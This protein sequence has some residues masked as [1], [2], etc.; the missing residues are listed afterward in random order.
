M[1]S[2][3]EAII[4]GGGIVG[5]AIAFYL[6][7]LGMRDVV[8]I[9]KDRFIGAGATAKC[10]G[11]IRAQFSSEINIKMSLMSENLLE[12][13]QDETGEEGIFDQCGYLFMVSTDEHED[14]FRKNMDLQLANDVPVEWLTPDDIR[15][16]APNVRL[17]DILGGTFCHKDGIGD[18]HVFTHGYANAA[19]KL[20]AVVEV[21]TEVTGIKVDNGKITGVS[22]NKGDIACKI[23]INA[24]G[25]SSASIGKMIGVDLPIVPVKRQISTTSPLAW[26]DHRFPMVVDVASGLYCHRESGGLLLGWADP[27]T[28]PGFDESLDPDYTDEIIMKAMDRIPIL[29]EAG[30]ATSWA[31]LYSVTPDHKAI[32]G[33]VPGVEGF[34]VAA[35]FS[36]HGFMHAPAVGKLIAE[37][38]TSESCSIDLSPLSFERFKES[39]KELEKVV[40]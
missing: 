12:A 9:E 21:E 31:G 14:I 10:A 5:A 20:G 26:L 11:G 30:I 4:V 23:V 29:E 36:G 18:P 28:A 33:V 7:K 3:A 6:E 8:I 32:L 2:G 37:L 34:I 40:I 24:A 19:K 35:G 22:T 39:T 38:V 15:E 13:F 17:D 25:P 16:F 1:K 27:D